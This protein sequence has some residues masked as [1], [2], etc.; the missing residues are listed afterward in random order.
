MKEKRQ[1]NSELYPEAWNFF[2]DQARN[3]MNEPILSAVAN[4]RIPV[5]DKSGEFIYADSPEMLWA[6][7]V[8]KFYEPNFNSPS[9]YGKIQYIV[10]NLNH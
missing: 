3:I 1:S 4:Y 10:Q 6:R 9:V 8:K 7:F 5:P 2:I